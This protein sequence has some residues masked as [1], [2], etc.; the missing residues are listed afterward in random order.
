MTVSYFSDLS[1]F[2]VLT[3]PRI[4]INTSTLCVGVPKHGQQSAGFGLPRTRFDGIFYEYRVAVVTENSSVSFGTTTKENLSKCFQ[5]LPLI[6]SCWTCEVER[7][8][9]P[10][11]AQ[12]TDRGVTFDL[13]NCS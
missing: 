4:T 2:Q 10:V 5:N 12:R 9:Q 6:N 11:S 1:H 13:N 7:I 3:V 8:W